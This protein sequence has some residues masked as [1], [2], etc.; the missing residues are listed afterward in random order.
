MK[1]SPMRR[2]QPLVRTSSLHRTKPMGEGKVRTA[3]RNDIAFALDQF[4]K[5]AHGDARCQISR[6]PIT[7]DWCVAHHKIPASE[8][9]LAKV[10][11]LDAPHRLLVLD[12]D[13]HLWWLHRGEMGRPKD[14]YA[15]RIYEAVEHSPANAENGLKVWIPT[16]LLTNGA[17]KLYLPR[18][19]EHTHDE[20][21]D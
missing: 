16:G 14:A 15:R 13:V 9:R 2:G 20:A 19:G 7:R 17:V 5:N 4:F 6:K 1:R 18:K 12:P 10:K 11:D 21:E 8:L 3:H